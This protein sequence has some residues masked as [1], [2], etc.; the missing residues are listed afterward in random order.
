MIIYNQTIQTRLYTIR[1]FKH[2]YRPPDHSN[3]N[4]DNQIIQT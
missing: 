4:I 3:M 1:P 2:D